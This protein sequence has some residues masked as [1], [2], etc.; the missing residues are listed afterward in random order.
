MAKR[1]GL[2]MF[3]QGNVWVVKKYD[4]TKAS[5]IRNTKEEAWEAARNIAI[6]QNLSVTIHGRDG[7][8]MKTVT[9]RQ[10]A[11]NDCFLTTACTKYFGLNDDCYQLQTLRNFRDQHLSKSP[12]GR[13]LVEQYYLIGPRLVE[14]LESDKNRSLLFDEI[15]DEINLSC[16]AIENKQFEKARRI[17]K[18]V[19]VR[20][21]KYYNIQ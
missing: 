4:S 12:Q 18:T 14:A 16:I 20:L 19:V 3:P 10:A 6:N 7:K 1:K 9:P 8:V 2:Q 13:K 21:L 11:D 17:Y 5:A 15:F